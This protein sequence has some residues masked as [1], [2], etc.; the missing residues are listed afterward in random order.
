[1]VLSVTITTHCGGSIWV[2]INTG[3]TIMKRA[4]ALAT[5]LVIASAIPMSEPAEACKKARR[6]IAG[7]IIGAGAATVLGA[8]AGA[9]E[10]SDS[11]PVYAYDDDYDPEQNAVAACLHRA[12]RV[13]RADGSEGTELRRVRRV[14][15]I[16]DATYRVDLSL[17]AYNDG[18]P[19]RAEASCR[20]ED[21]RVTRISIR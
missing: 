13:L 5:A 7:I 18:Y 3:A 20:V 12:Y 10:R 9:A 17:I 16:G 8:A 2:A 4:L 21:E 15:P 6:I 14:R 19:D 1:M 11:D